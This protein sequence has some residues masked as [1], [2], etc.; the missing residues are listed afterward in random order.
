[1]ANNQYLSPSSSGPSQVLTAAVASSGPG[2]DRI[3]AFDPTTGKVHPS[4]LPGAGDNV[5]S[6]PT[7]ENFSA[8]VFVNVYDASGT[9][10]ARLA[11]AANGRDA[12]GFV[13]SAT[14]SGQNANVY[15]LGENS[16]LSGLTGGSRYYLG[17]AGG[18]TPTPT[19]SSGYIVQ[20]LGKAF[21]SSMIPFTD[22]GFYS[23]P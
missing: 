21:S 22:K 1:M 9:V 6:M 12:N 11:D 2:D 20:E 19:Q 16:S 18:V 4:A 7:S 17:T 23:Y 5:T 8:G 3:V 10:T 15:S 14:T 13:L